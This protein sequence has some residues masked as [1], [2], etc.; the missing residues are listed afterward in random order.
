MDYGKWAKR[1]INRI[2]EPRGSTATVEA[3]A[4]RLGIA[5]VTM[6]GRL[7][8]ETEF[9]TEE[10]IKAAE[11]FGVEPPIKNNGHRVASQGN[12]VPLR[13]EAVPVDRDVVYYPVLGTVEAGAF[14]E[15]D[16]LSQVEPRSVPGG[17]NLSYPNATPMAWEVRGDSM[18]QEGIIDGTVVIGV[19]FSETG[20]GLTNDMIVVVEQDR[21]GLIERSVK[22]VAKFPDRIEFQPRSTDPRH[23]P[24][25]YKNGDHNEDISVRI[26][27]VVHGFY[28]SL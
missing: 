11:F 6:Y 20:G 26:L 2:K 17:K 27:T 15:H 16:M 24:I 14:R 13:P 18:N 3:L 10:I 22:A 25:T 4:K 12:V 5:K 9:T 1:E 19:D 28:R 8:G 21:G 7:R 23:K